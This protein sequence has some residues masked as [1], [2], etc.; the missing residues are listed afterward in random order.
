MKQPE[1][2]CYGLFTH[3]TLRGAARVQAMVSVTPVAMRAHALSVAL[4]RAYSSVLPAAVRHDERPS[5]S[6]QTSTRYWARFMVERTSA[7]TTAPTKASDK[8]THQSFLRPR[9]P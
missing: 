5:K 7:A 6:M 2:R 4:R 9:L 8:S 1:V 3:L